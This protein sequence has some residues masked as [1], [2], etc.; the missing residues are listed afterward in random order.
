MTANAR[1]IERVEVFEERGSVPLTWRV[2]AYAAD[3]G[4]DVN[5]F[6]DGDAKERAIDYAGWRYR[7]LYK[8][9]VPERR[10]HDEPDLGYLG[11]DDQEDYVERE[12]RGFV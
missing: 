10:K 9:P 1:Q 3:G 8:E 12:L 11:I 7:Y 4:V 5:I 2:E 6:C